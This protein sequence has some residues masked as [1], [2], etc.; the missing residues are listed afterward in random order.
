MA[1][2]RG[3]MKSGSII[4]MNKCYSSILINNYIIDK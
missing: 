1:N 3:C 4:A 2:D